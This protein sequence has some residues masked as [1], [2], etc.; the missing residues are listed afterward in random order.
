MNKAERK[1]KYNPTK[2]TLHLVRTSYQI[3]IFCEDSGEN[4]PRYNDT[5]LSLETSHCLNQGRSDIE[6]G[7]NRRHFEDICCEWCKSLMTSS[8]GNILLVNAR[9][10]PFVWGIH[11]SPVNSPHKGQWRG[12]LM[13][14]LIC[15]WTNRWANNGDASDLKH[16]RTHYDVILMRHQFINTYGKVTSQ[17]V[18]TRFTLCCVLLWLGIDLSYLYVMEFHVCVLPGRHFADDIF[19]CVFLNENARISTRISPR[20]VP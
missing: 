9:Y 18:C 10:W 11:R 4:W 19:K 3:G 16:H 15:N 12:A 17:Q 5:P 20:F 13:F 6:T 7:A 8:N 1:S 2:D 14:S